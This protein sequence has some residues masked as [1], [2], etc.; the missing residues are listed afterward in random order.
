MFFL[1]AGALKKKDRTTSSPKD[2]KPKQFLQ[3]Q[4]GRNCEAMHNIG[5][6]V[7]GLAANVGMLHQTLDKINISGNERVLNAEQLKAFKLWLQDTTS[8]ASGLDAQKTLSRSDADLDENMTKFWQQL[9]KL[10]DFRTVMY[11]LLDMGS[12]LNGV[13]QLLTA[14]AIHQNRSAW[15]AG[16]NMQSAGQKVCPEGRV[17]DKF[18]KDP[19]NDEVVVDMLVKALK[20]QIQKLQKYRG[21]S[22]QNPYNDSGAA[23]RG[24]DSDTSSSSE[25]SASDSSA[26]SA[27]QGGKKAGKHKQQQKKQKKKTRRSKSTSSEPSKRKKAMKN[28]RGKPTADISEE[29]HEG[30]NNFYSSEAAAPAVTEKRQ[31]TQSTKA[32]A[33]SKPV[34]A[35]DHKKGAGSS[36]QPSWSDEEAWYFDEDNHLYSYKS[37][38]DGCWKIYEQ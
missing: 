2:V 23:Q 37:T 8:I 31:K 25:S 4:T 30:Q 33:S 16:I 38:R 29:E 24:A 12:R 28:K 11:Q 15:K 10:D 7:S 22:D 9:G 27:K 13:F 36:S 1:F 35:H 26:S 5:L 21:K 19:K 18:L 3:K 34:P 20:D 6:F 17:M 14:N 32:A